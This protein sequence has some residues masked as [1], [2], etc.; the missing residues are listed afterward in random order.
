MATLRSST[1]IPI[2]YIMPTFGCDPELFISTSE[3]VVGAEKFIQDGEVHG[4]VL[5][6]VQ[7]ELN[8]T[9]CTC[10]QSLGYYIGMAMKDLKR[11]LLTKSGAKVTFDAVVTVSQKE[12]DSLSDKAKVFGCAQSYN[13]YMPPEKAAITVNP[14][15]YLKRSAGGHIH[16]GLDAYPIIKSKREMLVP[17]F[18]IFVGNTSIMID[19]DPEAVERRKVYGRAGEYRLPTHGIEYRTPSNFWMRNYALFGLVFG[20]T[21]MACSV[22]H[23]G[24]APEIIDAINI[25]EVR[26]AINGNDLA[27]A[28]SNWKIVRSFIK[29]HKSNYNNMGIAHNTLD[30]F[31]F[32]CHKVQENGI[33]YWFPEDPLEHWIGIHTNYMDK[34][35]ESFILDKVTPKMNTIDE[36]LKRVV[37]L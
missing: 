18:D 14:A 37:G 15:S 6:G 34:G 10:R 33:G 27:L 9:P 5:D 36:Q 31:D 1:P 4:C 23:S 25:D 19:R 12:L 3:G 32:F 11:H 16:V 22:L 17:I 7:I 2:S 24:L 30:A 35:F 29:E 13:A 8:P 20:L 21:R 26:D 28:Q